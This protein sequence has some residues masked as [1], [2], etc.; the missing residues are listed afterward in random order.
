LRTASMIAKVFVSAG[1]G[2]LA[3]NAA[4][5]AEAKCTQQTYVCT[6][7]GPNARPRTCVTTICTDADGNITSTNTIVLNQG[8]GQG[9]S[10]NRNPAKLVGSTPAASGLRRAY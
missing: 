2:L 10:G 6:D 5:A 7:T 8:G 1:L 4:S 9:G 3:I